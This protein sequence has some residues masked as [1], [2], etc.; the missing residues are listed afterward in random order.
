LDTGAD[1]SK[2]PMSLAVPLRVVINPREPAHFLGVGGQQAKGF[3]GTGVV[4]ELRQGKR[5][6]RWA[7]PKVAFVYDV[8][9]ADDEGSITITLGHVGFFRY[10]NVTFD[11]Q[12]SRVEIRPNGLF[13][14]YGP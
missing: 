3:Y 6:Y 1:E 4:L 13:R 9:G 2:L 10:F 11:S 5:S 12:R 7:V 8:P 14:S